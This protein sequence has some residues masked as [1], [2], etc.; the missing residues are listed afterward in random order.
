MDED[1]LPV[2]DRL[3][4]RDIGKRTG[5]II[6]AKR[7]IIHADEALLE[8]DPEAVLVCERAE[9]RLRAEHERLTGGS[10]TP[11]SVFRP[12]C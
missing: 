4:S 8:T 2:G 10:K 7:D 11:P 3:G 12:W 6:S 1:D 9:S 5:D